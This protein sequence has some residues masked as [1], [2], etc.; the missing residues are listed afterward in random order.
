MIHVSSIWIC[1][2]KRVLN[3]SIWS[4]VK[5]T[6]FSY[7]RRYSFKETL[8]RYGI[9]GILSSKKRRASEVTKLYRSRGQIYKGRNRV[10]GNDYRYF[11]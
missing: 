5:Y 8:R 9:V 6:V 10:A 7:E 1:G 4:E 3:L 11:E 2:L